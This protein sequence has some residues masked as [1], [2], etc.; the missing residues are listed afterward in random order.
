MNLDWKI[1]K[2]KTTGMWWTDLDGK[3]IAESSSIEM[4][5]DAL[6]R[7]VKPR[8]PPYWTIKI[9]APV[10]GPLFDMRY[11]AAFLRLA[12]RPPGDVASMV[13]QRGDIPPIAVLV[14][15]AWAAFLID[16][17]S[18]LQLAALM[19]DANHLLWRAANK[20]KWHTQDAA[21]AQRVLEESEKLLA[22][23]P[24]PKSRVSADGCMVIHHYEDEQPAGE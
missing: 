8:L 16:Y 19:H 7:A 6:E 15:D 9:Y 10:P 2:D 12:D 5:A 22:S 11:M 21:D 4:A 1:Y 17:P 13:P 14:A 3:A 23:L 18:Q 24:K 20:A